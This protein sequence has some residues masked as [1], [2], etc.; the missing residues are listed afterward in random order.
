[1]KGF[2]S[3][4]AIL[5]VEALCDED[6]IRENVVN[7]YDDNNRDQPSPQTP[8]EV[9][10]VANEPYEDEKNRYR[11]CVSIFVVFNELRDL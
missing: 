11:F 7:R 8:D 1:M 5:I 4:V 2:V 10:N 3:R 6:P 9:R